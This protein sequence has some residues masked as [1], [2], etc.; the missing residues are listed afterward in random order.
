MEI[1]I[2]DTTVEISIMYM[3]TGTVLLWILGGFLIC[4]CCQ[5]TVTD[6]VMLVYYKLLKMVG[7]SDEISIKLQS[8]QA[9]TCDCESPWYSPC[10]M[11]GSKKM[12]E[13]GCNKDGGCDKKQ[14]DGAAENTNSKNGCKDSSG[15]CKAV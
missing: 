9:K 4:S 3:L 8:I 6:G 12:K 1:K 15:E 5:Y 13:A 7:D 11:W 2:L 10:V 14:L